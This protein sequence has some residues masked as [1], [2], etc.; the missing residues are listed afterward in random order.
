MRLITVLV[1]LAFSGG[2]AFAQ[3]TDAMLDRSMETIRSYYALHG[4]SRLVQ[5]QLVLRETQHYNGPLDG[6]WGP[7]T[8]AAFRRVV[9]TRIA[10]GGPQYGMTTKPDDVPAVTDWAGALILHQGGYG[11]LP[12]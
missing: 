1:F 12:D 8:A 3:A 5:A 6:Q 7:G 4:P 9:S 10:I 2:G 11:D